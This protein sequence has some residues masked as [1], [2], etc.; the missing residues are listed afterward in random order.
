MELLARGERSEHVPVLLGFDRVLSQKCHQPLPQI[1]LFLLVP[2]LLCR[3]VLTLCGLHFGT[4]ILERQVAEVLGVI[5]GYEAGLVLE[6]ELGLVVF[7]YVFA[8]R[9]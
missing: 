4:R 5:K 1:R 7:F 2:R 3:T 8:Q 9:G 6:I